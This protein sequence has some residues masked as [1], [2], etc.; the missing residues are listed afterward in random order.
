M[1]LRSANAR[2][3]SPAAIRAAILA[4]PH[5]ADGHLLPRGEGLRSTA[6]VH[7]D[8]ENAQLRSASSLL[9]LLPRLRASKLRVSESQRCRIIFRRHL[10]AI[11]LPGEK[12][13]VGRMRGREHDDERSEFDSDR[14]MVLRSTNA[15][16]WSPARDH[17][18]DPRDPSSGLRPPSPT[19]GEGLRSTARVHC[20]YENAQL[21]SASS[22]L[23]LL[24]RLRAS[25]LRVSES[26]RCRI[27]FRRHLRAILLPGEKVPVGRMRGREHDDER[28][29]FDSDRLMVLRSANARKWSPAAIRAAI[30]AT[31]HPACGHLLPRGEGLRSTARVHCDYE[32]AQ[33]RSASSLLPLLPRLR[34]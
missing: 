17:S 7:C 23:P 22:L 33:L 19:R 8:Y 29:E 28:S 9:P 13:P 6:R 1:V 24:P 10:R 26:Q 30:L 12:V 21:R 2:K 5:P 3:W 25:K 11:L 34:A 18:H 20:D 27:I 14:L 4:T 32:N 15:R 31:P 16:K